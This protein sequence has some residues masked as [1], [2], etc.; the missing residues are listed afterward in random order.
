MPPEG[1]FGMVEPRR[2]AEALTKAH[3]HPGRFKDDDRT[4]TW[5]LY[6][7]ALDAHDAALGR[8]LAALKTAGRADDTLVVVTSD[9]A[10]SE[11]PP[12]PFADAETLD[13]PLLA[14]PLV[15]RWPHADGLAAR[16]VDA[17][18]SPVD[19]ARTTL[20]ALGLGPPQAFQGVDL[21]RLASGALVPAE[22]PLLA[23]RGGR[24]AARWGTLV[25]SGARDRETRLCDLALDP[26]CVADVR[27]TTP[28]AYEPLHRWT[29][30]ALTS[31]TPA[32]YPREPI[33]ADPHVTAM[34]VR[35]GRP[36]EE[37]DP[38]DAN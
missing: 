9:A 29:V 4:R 37:K 24:F 26:T 30:A 35:W 12:V 18:T 11:A 3:K 2:A 32:P 19:L 16:R 23:T 7:R 8:L 28:L 21:A 1:Y 34:L 38:Q 14:V 5:A 25:L 15:F 10:A 20:A 13:E 31:S 22:R 6:D 27:A 36:T 33:T 17:P